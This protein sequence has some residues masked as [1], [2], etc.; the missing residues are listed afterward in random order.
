MARARATIARPAKRVHPAA[1]GRF[2][3]GARAIARASR[4][5]ERQRARISI[6]EEAKSR[7]R[8]AVHG[9]KAFLRLRQLQILPMQMRQNKRGS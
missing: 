3:P 8:F 9:F 1:R 5:A 4:H 7:F 2:D 6:P